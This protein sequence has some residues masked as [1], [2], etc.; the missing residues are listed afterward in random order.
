MNIDDILDT[1]LNELGEKSPK[2]EGNDASKV[3][4][5]VDDASSPSHQ[6]TSTEEFSDD[7]NELNGLLSE[8]Q[9]QFSQSLSMGTRPGD[10]T[11]EEIGNMIRE[12]SSLLREAPAPGPVA[13]INENVDH[14]DFLDELVGQLLS[15][16]LM[17]EPMNEVAKRFPSWLELNRDNISASDLER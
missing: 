11:D 13:G 1:A 5:R 14:D 7:D 12:M 9:K 4:A 17:Y 6:Q 3:Q 16:D 8:M 2:K 10:D 15:K